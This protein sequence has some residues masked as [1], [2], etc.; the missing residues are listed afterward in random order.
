MGGDLKQCG[1]CRGLP[2]IMASS[3]RNLR[4]SRHA[5]REAAKAFWVDQVKR[6]G[7]GRG[8][9]QL[10][11]WSEAIRWD[12]ERLEACRLAGEAH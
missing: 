2:D 1:V 5:G 9:W 10:E 6:E 11:Q 3:G 8:E 7:V 4:H 12:L